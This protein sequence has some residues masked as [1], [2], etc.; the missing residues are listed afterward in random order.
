MVRGKVLKAIREEQ[1][2]IPAHSTRLATLAAFQANF[3]TPDEFKADAIIVKR[4]NAANHGSPK[5]KKKHWADYAI[6]D[7]D[8]ENN[9][10]LTNV[11]TSA[12]D[13]WWANKL[14]NNSSNTITTN[15]A[16]HENVVP[17]S[18]LY[19]TKSAASPT[20]SGEKSANSKSDPSPTTEPNCSAKPPTHVHSQRLLPHDFGTHQTTNGIVQELFGAH[21]YE[22]FECFSDP[23][24][25]SDNPENSEYSEPYGILELPP[26]EDSKSEASSEN[27]NIIYR[28]IQQIT[29]RSTCTECLQQIP[30]TSDH[31]LG[32]GT[33]VG[34][35]ISKLIE[36]P[37]NPST[38]AHEK[39]QK[40]VAPLQQ[41]QS[42][43]PAPEPAPRQDKKE[44][45]RAPASPPDN[46]EAFAS[47]NLQANNNEIANE[48]TQPSAS[49][50][51]DG[52]LRVT[53]SSV[54]LH[55][56][57]NEESRATTNESTQPY[58]PSANDGQLR[59]TSSSEPTHGH[60]K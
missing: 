12:L 32:C 15:K 4:Q 17:C 25:Y 24:C 34:L 54:P 60:E 57:E 56:H 52:Q 14:P 35:T 31:C 51:N 1:V 8:S 38:S 18:D 13:K 48:I 39:P 49:S 2:G 36:I 30:K 33:P 46:A 58:A 29:D 42:L 27:N 40:K 37:N 5:P 21:L 47:H 45:P 44:R 50:A 55:G 10:N 26:E 19:V 28:T 23:E 43:P 22:A 59:V 11:I 41:S 16:E 3:T 9:K 6:E 53:S 20:E 7:E